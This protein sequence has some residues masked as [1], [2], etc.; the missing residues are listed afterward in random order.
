MGGAAESQ[1][2]ARTV[3]KL[4]TIKSLLSKHRFWDRVPPAAGSLRPGSRLADPLLPAV[5]SRAASLPLTFLAL[6]LLAGSPGCG[7]ASAPCA[8]R[9]ATL[10]EHR[11]QVEALQ[12]DLGRQAD[13]EMALES[14]RD[15]AAR[16]IQAATALEDSLK[17]SQRGAR[18]P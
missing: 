18:R 15:E 1:G 3:N 4:L 14:R 12:E 17:R 13:E 7:R 2:G 6:S 9:P 11:R 8:T 10:D 16:R 5:R